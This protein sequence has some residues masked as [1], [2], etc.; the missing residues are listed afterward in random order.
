MFTIYANI[1]HNVIGCWEIDYSY[2]CQIIIGLFDF[3]LS[4]DYIMMCVYIISEGSLIMNVPNFV[5]SGELFFSPIRFF[6]L[7]FWIFCGAY[8]LKVIQ[9]RH[10]AEINSTFFNLIA[11]I[12][13]PITILFALGK[14]FFDK[15]IDVWKTMRAKAQLAAQAE[16]F[17]Y[18]GDNVSKDGGG[19]TLRTDTKETIDFV[20]RIITRIINQGVREV[21]LIPEL[22]GGYEVR[23][24]KQD[25][26]SMLM[27]V[28][29][30]LS[31]Q[32]LLV[33]KSL[34]GVDLYE[35]KRPQFGSFQVKCCS[36][37]FRVRLGTVG[38]NEGEQISLHF[39]NIVPVPESLADCGVVS[40]DIECLRKIGHQGGGIV[41]VSGPAGCGKRTFIGALLREFNCSNHNVC[42]IG[43]GGEPVISR[44]TSMNAASMDSSSKLNLL[45]YAVNQGSDIVAIT[46]FDGSEMITALMQLVSSGA[47]VVLGM[48]DRT[49]FEALT[50]F[51]NAGC[52]VASL[53][54]VKA[55]VILR[56][57]RKLCKC[58]V[59]TT[60]PAEYREYFQGSNLGIDNLKNP[61][62]CNECERTG[63]DGTL[64]VFEVMNVVGDFQKL[65][66]SPTVTR[67]QIEEYL[68]NN[69]RNGELIGFNL[70]SLA[71]KGKTSLH[72]AQ[73]NI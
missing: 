45:D 26:F 31:G 38:V 11:L 8:S 60:L 25:R 3:F 30:P 15:Q 48:E 53:K 64:G 40:A 50:N 44:V 19:D 24:K 20:S 5:S 52:P 66:C 61:V 46:K 17:N 22:S 68:V 43:E 69:S 54:L 71:A 23:I 18:Q 57:V 49:V 73:K 35:N 59:S 28:E 34:A 21:V 37:F 14:K 7:V 16:L 10:V 4:G 32:V 39:H 42:W 47:L 55:V 67:Q 13:G 36:N 9:Q 27:K 6:V 58:A 70:F 56:Q 51:L 65:L 29:N 72:E 2:N 12:L 63:Y 1:K 33:M 41:L 62:G